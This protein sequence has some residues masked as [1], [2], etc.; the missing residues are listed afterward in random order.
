MAEQDWESERQEA[1][2]GLASLLEAMLKTGES[3]AGLYLTVDEMTKA[4]DLY[5]NVMTSLNRW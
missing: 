3:T 2:E 5:V 1:L 4:F